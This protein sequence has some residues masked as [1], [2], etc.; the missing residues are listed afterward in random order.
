MRSLIRVCQM[1]IRTSSSCVCPTCLPLFVD[2][3]VS[4]RWIAF[5]R[6]A[7]VSAA[8]RGLPCACQVG[9]RWA[10]IPK[11]Y[12]PDGE[13]RGESLPRCLPDG[14]RPYTCHRCQIDLCPVRAALPLPDGSRRCSSSPP[15]C[16]MEPD[17]NH[18]SQMHRCPRR[19]SRCG[20]NGQRLPLGQRNEKGNCVSDRQRIYS[21]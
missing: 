9:R 4:A 7:P 1:D 21:R 2:S 3:S 11:V 8:L 16:Q 6:R 17:R 14:P 19:N 10:G 15:I 18:T 13:Q 12:L 20:R 5:G